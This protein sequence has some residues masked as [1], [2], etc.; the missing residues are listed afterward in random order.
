MIFGQREDIWVDIWDDI[1]DRFS[2]TFWYWWHFLTLYTH[3]K[4]LRPGKVTCHI[5]CLALTRTHARVA[6]MVTNNSSCHTVAF[7]PL[8]F[9]CSPSRPIRKAQPPPNYQFYWLISNKITQYMEYMTL[10]SVTQTYK[11]DASFR[12]CIGT[13]TIISQSSLKQIILT[14]SIGHEKSPLP[15]HAIIGHESLFGRVIIS[16]PSSA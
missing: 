1:D 2:L 12:R 7:T 15:E 9:T 14:E 6:I 4:A 5:N 11:G 13:P 3:D 8:L 10:S 16:L